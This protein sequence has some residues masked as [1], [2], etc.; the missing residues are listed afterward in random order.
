MSTFGKKSL[1]KWDYDS[2]DYLR[3]NHTPKNMQ[4]KILEKWYPLNSD[5][6]YYTPFD[7][8]KNGNG[9]RVKIIEHIETQ[10]S[11]LIRFKYSFDK[12]DNTLLSNGV[13]P[14]RL[15]PSKEF[16]RE[17]KLKQILKNE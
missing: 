15:K 5:F 12:T 1:L 2:F 13:N 16:L 11:W 4:L 6:Q 3:Y 17:V 10:S 9:V 7:K 8:E 14:L